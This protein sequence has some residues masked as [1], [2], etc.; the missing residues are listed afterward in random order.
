Q[1]LALGA[2]VFSGPGGIYRVEQRRGGLRI[3]APF[4]PSWLRVNLLPRAEGYYGVELRLWGLN[5]G[6]LSRLEPIAQGLEGRPQIL[7][8][9]RLWHWRLQG[10]AVVTLTE[11]VPAQENAALDAWRERLGIYEAELTGAAYRLAFD[12]N[13]ANLSF[14]RERGGR[15][16]RGAA[17]PYCVVDDSQLLSCNL[18]LLET[19]VR[20]GLR[21]LA[22]G[23]LLDAYGV[24]Y[25]RR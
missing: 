5:L 13:S 14:G 2:G 24:Y 3:E 9:R 18:G 7:D 11:L 15:G 21:A 20:S 16:R 4:L 19:G 10:A 22:D 17:E 23:R 1:N 8:G 25:R 12:A 6:W